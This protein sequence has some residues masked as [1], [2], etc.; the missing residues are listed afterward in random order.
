MEKHPLRASIGR[1]LEITGFVIL[2]LLFLFIGFVALIVNQDATSDNWIGR[3]ILYAI[4]MALVSAIC[5]YIELND[6]RHKDN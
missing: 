1:A 4:V 2:T 6:H 3:W 5:G